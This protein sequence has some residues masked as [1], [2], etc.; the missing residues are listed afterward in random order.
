MIKRIY[1]SF[2]NIIK[3]KV[4]ELAFFLKLSAYKN[5]IK[6]GCGVWWNAKKRSVYEQNIYKKEALWEP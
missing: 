3:I 1:L 2:Q 6:V 5:K 4:Q